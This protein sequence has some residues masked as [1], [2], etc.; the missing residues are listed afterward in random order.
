MTSTPPPPPQQPRHSGGDQHFIHGDMTA[1][2]RRSQS[3]S[4]SSPSLSSN[5]S[6]TS[7]LSFRGDHHTPMCPRSPLQF[8]GVPF[9]WEKIPGIPKHSNKISDERSLLPLPPPAGKQSFRDEFSPR[10]SGGGSFR[11]DPFF[12][13]LV[14]CSKEERH[15]SSSKIVTKSLSDRFGF[16]GLYAAASCKTTCAVSESIVHLPRSRDYDLLSRRSR[17]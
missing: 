16:M 14:E 10:K 7:S 8:M 13:A 6:F 5:S 9:S 11:E 3:F 4:S 2:R 12:A 17:R 15:K 1:S